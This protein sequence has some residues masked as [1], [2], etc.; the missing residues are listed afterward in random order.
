MTIWDICSACWI[1]Q[2]INTHSEYAI[3]IVFPL[4]KLLHEHAYMLRY[5]TWHVLF[6]LTTDHL[7]TRTA[8]VHNEKRSVTVNK[9]GL[10]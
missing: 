9:V 10:P 8:A 3:I 1:P 2:A 5:I 4:Q 7:D 6:T